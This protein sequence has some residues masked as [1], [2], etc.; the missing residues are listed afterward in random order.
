MFNTVIMGGTGT[1]KSQK[2]KEIVHKVK[3]A[4]VFDYQNS[5]DWNFLPLFD[6][7]RFQNKCRI[8]KGECTYSGF[9]DICKSHYFN[10][11]ATI[12][13]EESK[14]LFPSN[15]LDPK[16]ND[17]LLS[18][19]HNLVNF[20]FMFH[21]ADQIPPFIL[22]YTDLVIVKRTDGNIKT[23]ERKFNEVVK[24]CADKCKK[25]IRKTYI[26]GVSN[27]TQGVFIE[28]TFKGATLQD[29]YISGEAL[30]EAQQKV[31]IKN[32]I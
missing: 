19:R 17:F 22:T 5:G 13:C 7:K 32:G 20:V 23:L 2:A 27:K 21:G 18:C 11:G 12:I 30:K 29:K 15:Q 28:E 1:G 16:V 9:M 26:I 24:E 8:T 14:G 10:V 4:F 31:N 6:P 25:D 3:I